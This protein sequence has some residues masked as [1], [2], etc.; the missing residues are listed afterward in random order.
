[1]RCRQAPTS[2]SLTTD[3]DDTCIDYD[4]QFTLVLSVALVV[5]VVLIFLRTI[6]ATIIAALRCRC[7]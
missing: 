1:M 7:P 2:R 3:H 4:V 6:R 5:L